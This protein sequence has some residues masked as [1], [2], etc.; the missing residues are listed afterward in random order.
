MF[1]VVIGGPGLKPGVKAGLPA[2]IDIDTREAG[3]APLEVEVLN[4]LN[5][6]VKVDVDEEE[7]GV[8]AATYYPDKPGKYTVNVKYGG[9]HVPKSPAK[10]DVKP[11]AD[12][13]K[14]TLKGP[15][16]ESPFVNEPTKFDVDCK[17][18]GMEIVLK[19]GQRIMIIQKVT[20][21]YNRS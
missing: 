14:C 10:I 16:L 6:K 11:K 1:A 9:K 7:P 20:Q 4:P 17:R 2:D 8:F 3:D 15:G 13:S 21:V 5:K 19:L 18:A 12:A